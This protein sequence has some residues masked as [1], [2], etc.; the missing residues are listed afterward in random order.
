M[1]SI[2]TISSCPETETVGAVLAAG[3]EA[4]GAAGAVVAGAVAAAEPRLAMYA[5]M[6]FLVTR[7][8]E[9]EPAMPSNSAGV[10]PSDWAML[11]TSG[12]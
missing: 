3:A 10:T 2:S 5:K 7:P 8:S 12:E 4:G 6:S 9:P 1:R 11:R